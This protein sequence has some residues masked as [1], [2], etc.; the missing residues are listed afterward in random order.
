MKKKC[1]RGKTTPQGLYDLLGISTMIRTFIEFPAGFLLAFV[2]S[3]L[4]VLLV[5]FCCSF[6][7][8][9]GF[10]GSSLEVLLEF[11]TLKVYVYLLNID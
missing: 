4:C 11:K 3:S 9:L 6:G 2:C 8:L 1:D 5:F 10:F 7:V